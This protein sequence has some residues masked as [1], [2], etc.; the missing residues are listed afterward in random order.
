M[1]IR[2]KRFFRSNSCFLLNLRI[3]PKAPQPVHL[4]LATEPCHLPLGVIAVSLLRRLQRLLS[5]QFAAKELY[6]LLV[7]QG[8][9]RA[10][11]ISVFLEQALCFLNQSVLE[12]FLRAAI[13]A[14][15]ERLTIG[16]EANTQDAES[17]ESI[18]AA[19]PELCHL[20]SRGEAD[21]DC[22]N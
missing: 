21:F 8:R 9:K 17:A 7:P 12:H 1:Q 18:T 4:R 10:Y 16:I 13:D 22:A 5:S 14:V 2:G 15:V 6:H 20:L 19:L 3:V 11:P